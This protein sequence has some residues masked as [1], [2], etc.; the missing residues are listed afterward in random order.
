M[1]DPRR[2]AA[3]YSRVFDA[4][5]GALINCPADV[6]TLVMPGLGTGYAGVPAEV[7]CKS[8]VFA[9]R[10]FALGDPELQNGLIMQFLGER[11]RGFYGE[12]WVR[13]CERRGIDVAALER[14]DVTRDSIEVLLRL[15]GV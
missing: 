11:Y 13:E 15:F 12:R 3:G 14:F 2:A 1:Y 9:L 5:W 7:A 10:V 8:M 6:E 4:M